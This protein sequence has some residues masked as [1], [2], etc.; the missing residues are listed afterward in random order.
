MG[1]APPPSPLLLRHEP[2]PP[3]TVMLA[4]LTVLEST[5]VLWT[6]S[7]LLD[8]PRTPT[9]SPAVVPSKSSTDVS[10]W[11]PSSVCSSRNLASPSLDPLTRREKFLSPP[12]WTTVWDSLPWPPSLP[13]DLSKS[14]FSEDLP[15]PSPCL[16][17]NTP[18]DPRTFLEVTTDPPEPSPEDTP[19]PPRSKT[20]RPVTVP[21]TSRSRTDV[22]PCLVFLDA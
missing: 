15:R 21:S 11:L 7:I 2:P 22:L 10:A 12:S 4:P 13:S 16:L 20:L 18:E 1:P 6:C 14:F 19:S 9:P 5:L 17:P 8:L 3:S